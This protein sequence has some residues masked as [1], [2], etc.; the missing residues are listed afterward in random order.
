MEKLVDE[1]LALGV[2]RPSTSPYSSPVLLVKKKNGG[3]S[4]CADY[5]AL[6]N[7]KI[8]NKFLIPVIEDLFDELNEATM[9]SKTDWKASYHQIRMNLEDVEK[10]AFFS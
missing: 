9:F 4:F 7:M 8:P 2:I 6:N 5:R 1:K 10:T 3:W